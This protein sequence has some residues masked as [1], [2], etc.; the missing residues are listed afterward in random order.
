VLGA[1]NKEVKIACG[2]RRPG[3]VSFDIRSTPPWWID[4]PG[5]SELL[6]L[7]AIAHPVVAEDVAAVP[8]LLSDCICVH[9]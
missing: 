6:G 9:A 1:A 4:G 7:V 2:D 8:E 3:E 5:N